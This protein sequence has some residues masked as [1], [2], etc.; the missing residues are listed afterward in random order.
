MILDNVNK[1]RVDAHAKDISETDFK[2]IRLHF[3]K[4]EQLF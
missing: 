2:Q 3:E 4:L 1:Y